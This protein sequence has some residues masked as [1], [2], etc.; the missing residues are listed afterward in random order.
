MSRKVIDQM[1][2]EVLIPEQPLRIVSL[3][4]SQT[5]LLFDLGLNEEIIGITNFCIHPKEKIKDRQKVGGTKRLRIDKIKALAPDLIIGNKEENNKEE[6]LALSESFPV[7]MSDI[8]TLSD[9]LEMIQA[10]GDLVHRKTEANTIVRQLKNDFHQLSTMQKGANASVAYFIWNNPLM[11]A[12][13]DTFIDEIL[14]LI[15]FKNAFESFPRYPETSFEQLQ[16]LQPDYIF[17]SSEP[18][19]FQQK[20]ISEFVE[21]LPDSKTIIVDGEMFSWYGSRMLHLKKYIEQ[22]TLE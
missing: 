3:V 12:G 18:Y 7:W 17:L 15:G 5:E 4:P 21:K 6:I 13:K 22:L 11:V 20:H 10:F 16:Q 8:Q 9:A 2:R 1:N 14:Q 19:P